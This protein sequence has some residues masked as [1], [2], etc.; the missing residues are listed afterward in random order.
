MTRRSRARRQRATEEP[1]TI[2][3]IEPEHPVFGTFRVESASGGAYEVE[4]RSLVRQD[5]TCGCPDHR[6]NGLGT[7][8]HVEAVLASLSAAQKRRPAGQRVEV[9]LRNDGGR[10]LLY[11]GP[12]EEQ[13]GLF[14]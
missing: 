1:F 5:N 7:C 6:V 14:E 11:A 8:K 3:A 2:E 9:F 4:V 12:E 13:R 10:R